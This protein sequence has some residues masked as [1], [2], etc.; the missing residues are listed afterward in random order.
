MCTPRWHCFTSSTEALKLDQARPQQ[1]MFKHSSR[2]KCNRKCISNLTWFGSSKISLLFNASYSGHAVFFRPWRRQGLGS[3]WSWRPSIRRIPRSS[4][5]PRLQTWWIVDSWCTLTT[6]MKVMTSGKW[7]HVF[8]LC[9]CCDNC[10]YLW[11]AHH[12]TKTFCFMF[13]F[14]LSMHAVT[15]LTSQMHKNLLES[16]KYEKW[17]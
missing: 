6:G 12:F 14:F 2:T 5:W 15:S 8:V 4:A 16:V 13:F 11:T 17:Y 9:S 10:I 7:I 1:H 3:V